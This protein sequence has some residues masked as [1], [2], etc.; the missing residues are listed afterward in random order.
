VA[1]EPGPPLPVEVGRDVADRLSALLGADLLGVYLV[2]SGALGGFAP[3]TS[4]V[5]VAAIAAQGPSPDATRAI[6]DAVSAAALAWPVRGVEFVLYP[7][8]AAAA[9]SPQF[10]INLN[11][12]RRMPLHLA[13]DPAEEP[14][15]WFIIDLA[16]LRE[17][18]MPLLGPAAAELVGPV[19]SDQLLEALRA[20]LS[21]H[22]DNEP[23]SS[24]TVL[25]ACRAWRFVAEGVWSNKEEAGRW[26]ARIVEDTG[27]IAEALAGRKD[28]SRS[29]LDPARV[30]AFLDEVQTRISRAADARV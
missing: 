28:R 4:D 24:S 6:V 5:D 30:G 27:L 21:W 2:G 26:A 8:A 7:A 25:N 29:S 10:A 18:G 16:M 13:T 9:A 15:H 23:A 14:A 17:H 19:P 1:T 11:I 3:A 12:G 20:S 22:G